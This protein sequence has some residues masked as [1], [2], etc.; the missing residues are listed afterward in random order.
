MTARQAEQAPKSPNF[1]S[2]SMYTT[3]NP[4]AYASGA[5]RARSARRF[6]A[7]PRKQNS[8]VEPRSNIRCGAESGQ[9]EGLT[10]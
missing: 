10:R 1:R 7:V 6:L 2:E 9:G 5:Q 8:E 4:K 3:K